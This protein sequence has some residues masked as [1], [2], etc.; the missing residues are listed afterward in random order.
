MSGGRA[1][2]AAG[3]ESSAMGFVSKV[4]RLTVNTPFICIR[5]KPVR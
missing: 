2:A 1:G 5:G 3:V 4:V